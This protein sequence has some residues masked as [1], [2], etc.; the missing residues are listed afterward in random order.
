MVPLFVIVSS[1]AFALPNATALA[2]AD[3]PEVAG[4][5]SALLGVIQFMS[6]ALVAPL[7]GIAGTDTALPMALVMS[8][9]GIAGVAVTRILLPRRV[10]VS[11]A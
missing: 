3:H 2:L 4:V 1:F 5:A 10:A 7:V 9:L 11:A 6:G 8:A